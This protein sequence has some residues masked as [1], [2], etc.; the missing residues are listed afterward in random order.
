M[1][2]HTNLVENRVQ[3]IS[4]LKTLYDYKNSS[5]ISYREFYEKLVIN[6][7]CFVVCK[8]NDEIFIGPSKFVGYKDNDERTH[9]KTTDIRDGRVTNP[10]IT[11]LIG[12]LIIDG[13]HNYKDLE[14]LYLKYC[15]NNGLSPRER[16]YGGNKRKYWFVE[17]TDEEAKILK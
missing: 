3:I 10:Q 2:E 5:N 4:N 15:H 1:D 11:M 7:I 6:G 13:D 9:T 16:G 14:T 17:C 12:E 8:C